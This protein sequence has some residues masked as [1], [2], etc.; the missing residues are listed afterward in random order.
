VCFTQHTHFEM[1]PV[2]VW[3]WVC[4]ARDVGQ[5]QDLRKAEQPFQNFKLFSKFCFCSPLP[6]KTKSLIH[7]IFPVVSKEFAHWTPTTETQR[8]CSKKWLQG[9]LWKAWGKTLAFALFN[10]SSVRRKK[11]SFVACSDACLKVTKKV[12]NSTLTPFT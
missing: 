4:H 5:L 11:F 6:K 2:K 10:N 8:C 9:H 1:R 7:K 3:I 12:T